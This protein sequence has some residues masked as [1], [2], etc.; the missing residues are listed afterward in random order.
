MPQEVSISYQAVKSKV[1]KLVDAMVEGEKSPTEVQE[2]IRRWWSLIHPCDRAVAQ[3]YL[4]MVLEKSNSTLGAIIL[5]LPD[6]KETKGVRTLA[7]ESIPA[8][9]DRAAVSNLV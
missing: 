7:P 4:L 9:S 5:G 8:R 2:S 6:V 3:K 1:Y